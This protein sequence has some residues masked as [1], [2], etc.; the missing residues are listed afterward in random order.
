MLEHM[1]SLNL[2]IYDKSSDKPLLVMLEDRLDENDIILSPKNYDFLKEQSRLRIEAMKQYVQN[3]AKCRSRQLLSYF[4]E[5]NSIRCGECDVCLLRNRLSLSELEFDNVV[6]VIKP[7][8]RQQ[9]MSI[10]ELVGSVDIF[11]EEKVVKVLQWLIDNEKVLFLD[12]N[13]Y[14][15]KSKD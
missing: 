3:S 9:E 4:G 8:L 13:K 15:W 12:N 10:E 5:E 14:I 2:L 11:S 6:K 7:L 1:E